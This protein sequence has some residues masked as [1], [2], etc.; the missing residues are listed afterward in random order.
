MKRYLTISVIILVAF[1]P[2]AVLVS[3]S[4]VDSGDVKLFS[5]ERSP[6]I[7]EVVLFSFDDY[8][9]PFRK[10]VFLTLQSAEKYPKNPILRRGP[11]G[12]P[13]EGRAHLHGTVLRINGK[14]RM[15]YAAA[16]GEALQE[17]E[18]GNVWVSRVA[19]AESEDGIHW[20]KP[21]LGLVEYK[22]N[23]AN[24]LVAM[25]PGVLWPS[26]LYEPEEPDLAK[27]YKM[28][29][30]AYGGL[31]ENAV[32][33]GKGLLDRYPAAKL[34]MSPLCAYSADGLWWKLAENNPPLTAN[35]EGA[36]FYKFK[37][38]YF[39]QGQ[40]VNRWAPTTGMLLNG[41][42]TGRVLFTY[43]SPD[44]IHW[45]DAPALSF[46]RHG[47]RSAPQAT[48]EES[49]TAIGAW[50]RGNVVISPYLQWHGSTEVHSRW[51]DVGF[52]LSNDGIHFREPIPDFQLISRGAKNS[53]EGG[54][55]W[56]VSFLNVGDETLIYYSGLDGGGS[57][58]LGRGDIGIA[59]LKRDQFGYLS[60]KD[61]REVGQLM[62][63]ELEVGGQVKLFANV[64]NLEPDVNIR[65]GL[66]DE[67]YR[68][69]AGYSLKESKPLT[70][71]GLKQPVAWKQGE[72]IKGLAGKKVYLQAE[73]QGSGTK[74]PRLYA[75][76]WDT[77]R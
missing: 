57:T 61:T 2:L 22:G 70:V 31:A 8:S 16:D 58:A 56:G 15:W 53:W 13:D 41:D 62:T 71:S 30:K 17:M 64:D 26:V 72:V 75:I 39:L 28:M 6:E 29:F 11:A 3:A 63:S 36:N 44:S 74:S 27:R 10:N 40:I 65:L 21:N 60:L 47:Y 20:S 76:Y 48:V 49:H 7:R 5:V 12:S 4:A 1:S 52:M 24:N 54:S 68:P 38:S 42:S 9:I 46:M 50:D 66:V 69:I 34:T 67:R 51:M 25:E 33:R 14:F 32:R 37:G 73:L 55:V 77:V 18:R 35:L 43:R 59:T 23:K 45:T 19:Y